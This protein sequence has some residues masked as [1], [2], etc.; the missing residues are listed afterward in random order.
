MMSLQAD[1]LHGKNLAFQYKVDEHIRMNT[2]IDKGVE[3]I[4]NGT[5]IPIAAT[6]VG[7]SKS[8]TPG[9]SCDIEFQGQKLSNISPI[10]FHLRTDAIVWSKRPARETSAVL[11]KSGKKRESPQGQLRRS[12]RNRNAALKP[13]VLS[14]VAEVA[15]SKKPLTN[16][17]KWTLGEQMLKLS[18]TRP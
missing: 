10:D 1:R 12:K 13:S 3:V 2:V 4:Y 7:N 11:K 16:A 18:S 15:K 17:E 8:D 6:I 5:G 9:L 14:T